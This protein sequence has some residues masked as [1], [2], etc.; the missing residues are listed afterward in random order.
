MPTDDSRATRSSNN[1]T[2]KETKHS[3]FTTTT[4][5]NDAAKLWNLTPMSLRECKTIFAVKKQIKL[6][7]S[8]LPI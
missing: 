5:S 2:I 8:T 4:F 7:V 1:V 6:F 3:R